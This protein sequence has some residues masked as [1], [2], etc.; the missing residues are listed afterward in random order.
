[1]VVDGDVGDAFLLHAGKDK[2]RPSDLV[3]LSAIV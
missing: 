2:I 3:S 1:L